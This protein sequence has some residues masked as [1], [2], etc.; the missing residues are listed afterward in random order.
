M[1]L[2]LW[3]WIAAAFAALLVGLSKTG[4]PGLGLLFVSIFA[5]IMPPRAATGVVLPMLLVG[6][7]IAVGWYR[8]H[9]QWSRIWRLFPW[10]ACGVVMGY[11]ALARMSDRQVGLAVGVIVVGLVALQVLSKRGLAGAD[12]R[13]IPWWMAPLFGILAGFTTLISNAAGPLMLIYLLAM[14]LP[15]LEFIGTGA[16]YF[17]LLNLFKV[18]FMAHLGLI[19]PGSLRLNLA[20]APAVLVGAW[21]GRKVL[22]G[23]DQARFEKLMLGLT[24][25]AGLKLLL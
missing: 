9:A 17:L 18:P 2:L 7:V 10:A 3:Q 8:R 24:L 25:L 4:V 11:F 21:A 16:V 19:N 15:K 1:N 6:D 13:D 14:R 12:G 20:L 22:A 5:N 23:I